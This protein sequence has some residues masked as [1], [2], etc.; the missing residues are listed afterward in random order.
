MN[1]TT[2]NIL[3]FV[4]HAAAM[5]APVLSVAVTYYLLADPFKVL[6]QYDDYFPDPRLH[7]VHARV[8]K[9]MVTVRNYNA[10][11]AEGKN[12]NAF[13][14]GSSISC[15]YNAGLWASML[16]RDA[17][18]YHFDSSNE[19][20]VSMAEKV[21]YLDRQG[22]DL[23]YALIVLDPLVMKVADNNTSPATIHPPELHPGL[24]HRLVWHYRF[25]RASTNADFFK[26]WIPAQVTGVPCC[27]G[28]NPVFG[29]QPIVYDPFTNQESMPLWDS[30][31]SVDPEKFYAQHPLLPS[32]KKVSESKVVLE[33]EKADALTRIAAVF[34][35]HHTDYQ[36]VIGPNRRKVALNAT[37][38]HTL[39]HIF[40]PERVHDFSAVFATALESDTLL[41]DNT[42]YRPVFAARLLDYVY[43][44]DSIKTTHTNCSHDNGRL[45]LQ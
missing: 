35:A 6:W 42:H 2:K 27:Y 45:G 16:G 20:L 39:Q 26:S 9:G 24:V 28:R 36:V 25:F 7:P 13:I 29:T 33:R 44:K 10:R 4:L 19:S 8:N 40:V 1:N 14:F 32:P 30:M 22:V 34:M 43:N 15:Y 21:Q 31:I 5:T 41:Y 37:D 17:R 18:P 23:D 3:R 38:L 12:Y 11:K